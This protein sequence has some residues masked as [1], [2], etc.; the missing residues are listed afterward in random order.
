MIHRN[1]RQSLDIGIIVLGLLVVAF[2][3]Y[4]V[5]L[6]AVQASL[7]VRQKT[8]DFDESLF[9]AVLA[10]VGM[11]AYSVRRLIEQKREV[12][13]RM[14]AERQARELALQDP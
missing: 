11:F 8:I 10:T 3:C 5:D 2:V 1:K 12:R 13:R 9:L 14:T 4:E 6:F 7:S